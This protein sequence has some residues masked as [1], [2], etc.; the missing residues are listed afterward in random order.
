MMRTQRSAKT[1]HNNY[2]GALAYFS[3]LTIHFFH[4]CLQGSVNGNIL[5]ILL[6]NQLKYLKATNV[7]VI[8]CSKT[9][10]VT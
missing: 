10:V 6:L 1:T 8:H 2:P 3:A 7:L 5:V 4:Y 9:M